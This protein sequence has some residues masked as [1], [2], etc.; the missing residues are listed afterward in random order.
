MKINASVA[1]DHGSRSKSL[2]SAY[3]SMATIRSSIRYRI[4]LYFLLIGSLILLFGLVLTN[5]FGI[6]TVRA[7]IGGN[8][9]ELA[10]VA[11]HRIEAALLEEQRH[12]K[13]LTRN[14]QTLGALEMAQTFY[15]HVNRQW[16]KQHVKAQEQLWQ[17]GFSNVDTEVLDNDLAQYLHS[18]ADFRQGSVIGI[19]IADGEGVVLAASSRP[20]RYDLRSTAWWQA[21]QYH[22]SLYMSNILVNTSIFPER[23]QA[24]ELALPI[25]K[26][27]QIIGVAYIALRAAVLRNI[28]GEFHIGNTGHVMLVSG[29]GDPLICK[30]IPLGAHR[31]NPDLTNMVT[32][33]K[34]GWKIARND[35]HGGSNSIIG[36]APVRIQKTLGITTGSVPHWHTLVRQDPDETYA[37]LQALLWKVGWLGTLLLLLLGPVGLYAGKRIVKPILTLQQGARLI[38]AGNLQHRIAVDSQDE[39]GNLANEFNR[40]AHNILQTQEEL[41]N[42]ADAVIHAGDGII[43]TSL[44]GRIF[45]V[46]PSFETLTGYSAAELIGETPRKWK[47]NMNPDAL[48]QEMWDTILKDCIWSGELINKKKDGT[49]YT[50]QMTISPVSNTDGKMIS[51]LGVQRDVTEKR[52]LEHELKR[53]HDELELLVEERSQEIKQAKDKLESILTSANDVIITLDTDGNYKFI[54]DRIH[55]WGYQPEDLFGLPFTWLVIDNDG[56]GSINSVHGLLHQPLQIDQLLN[57]KIHEFCIHTKDGRIRDVMATASYLDDGETLVIARDMTET[58]SLQRQIAKSEQLRV[59]GEMATMVA[60]DFRNPLSTIKMNMQILSAKPGVGGDEKEHFALALDEVAV[61]EHLLT[62]I[63]DFSKPSLVQLQETDIHHS[64]THVLQQIHFE[65]EKTNVELLLDFQSPFFQVECDAEKIAQVWRNI[66]LNAIQSMAKGGTLR[67]ETEQIWQKNHPEV[68]I[69]II[70]TG[71]GMTK[72]VR[73]RLFDPFFT[74]R[75]GGTG[76]GLAIVKK[77]IESHH[78]SIDVVSEPGHGSEFLIALPLKMTKIKSAVNA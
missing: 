41:K 42:F 49:L 11:A 56:E 47:S 26:N 22:K 23:A 63:L 19:V 52:A 60:H 40:M 59:I 72:N 31:F 35:G 51:L 77:I 57:T 70:D 30:Y 34:P 64:L 38:G 17:T 58:K 18:I 25:L 69:H 21:V 71:C 65:L 54:N 6:Q 50:A 46:N 48:Y 76:L 27:K 62:S 1:T 16:I 43:M 8:F 7:T 78:G 33:A 61:L 20:S 15:Q 73:E 29:A 37:T 55:S 4:A 24:I 45:F 67:V 5:I 28:F 75:S 53:H 12:L 68:L 39:I 32:S 2:L 10:G 74:M 36:F 9:Q 44:D 13:D 3:H 14:P 66:F